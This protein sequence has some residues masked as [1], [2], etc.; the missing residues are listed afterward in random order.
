MPI[1][2]EPW[3]DLADALLQR[4]ALICRLAEGR[5]P[6]DFA[7]LYVA[8]D[9]VERL[10]AGLPGLDGPGP[11]R[12]AA[13]RAGAA[14]PVFRARAAFTAALTGPPASRFA[15]M[16]A[17]ARLDPAESEVLA[18]LLAVELSPARQRLV[19]YIQDSVQLPRLVLA[20]LDRIFAEPDQPDHPGARALA[21]A[22]GP[23][24]A[25]L[26]KVTGDGPW[27]TLTGVPAAR[28][29]WHLHG[30]D[31]PDPA[32]PAGT[33]L[34]PGEVTD[35]EPGLLLVHGGDRE[36]RLRIAGGHLIVLAPP[37]NDATWEAV[38][39]EAT[40]TRRT[41]VLDLVAPL[42]P[43]GQDVVRRAAHVDWVLSSPGELPLEAIPDRP[44]R[45]AHVPDGVADSA[46]WQA[47]LGRDP[48]PAYR[49]SREQLRLVAAAAA[50]DGGLVAPAVRR[51]AGGHLDGVAVRIRPRRAWDD[52]ILPVEEA[53]QLRELASRH[54]GRDT[55]YGTWKFNTQSSNGVV[56][57]FAG[58]SG[59][60]K[61]LAAE[62]VAGELGLDLYK[63]DLSSVV[64]KYIGETEKNLERIFGAAAA[65]DLVLF[66][67]EADAL[68]GKRSEV[69]DAHDRYA[70]IEVAYLLQRLERYDGMVVLATN[71]QRNIDPAF[72]R[73]I[74]VAIDFVPPEEPERRLIWA[75]AFPSS[76]PVADVDLDFLARQFKITGGVITNA[77]LGAAFLA[78]AEDSPITMRHAVLSVKR[79]F[80]KLGRLRTEKEF[81]RY[82][83]LINGDANAAPAG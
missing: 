81:D 14:A 13:V 19:A 79:E 66:F 46:D 34:R 10:L 31:A 39:R 82:F 72:Q 33:S 55:V 18:L 20:T 50:A 40:I 63:V 38:V 80:Q 52:L 69:S 83:D 2:A 26:A 73:R 16:V 42:P 21:P 15:A 29:I 57:L 71:L 53:A 17:A 67:D 59:T 4:E 62:V 25:G 35:R 45:E 9:E 54:R 11:E 8:D 41:V 75:R 30:D 68:F 7:G 48:D 76:A 56:A 6:R 22:A 47:A 74:S 1:T 60:G 64:S 12:V 23:I 61:T 28:V 58:P 27:A 5:P 65:G 78:A 43:A 36:S 51:L 70:N 37:E 24:R 49:L 3:T 32:L 77:A 44:W